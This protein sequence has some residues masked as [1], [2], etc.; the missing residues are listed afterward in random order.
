MIRRRIETIARQ[1]GRE[2]YFED[3]PYFSFP[4]PSAISCSEGHAISDCKLGYRTP[5]VFDTA[6]MISDDRQWADTIT[7]QPFDEARRY[8]MKFP[9]VGP[10]AADCILL[11]AFQKYEAFPVDVW[12]RRIIHHN[13]IKTL[14]TGS[15]LT[16][17]EYDT[18]RLFAKDHFGDYCGYAQEYLYAARKR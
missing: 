12:I 3:K 7:A 1:F 2:I 15:A 18:I 6:C 17:K 10:K 9:G 11:F 5:Y 13:Y 4:D 8:L 16:T 14:N